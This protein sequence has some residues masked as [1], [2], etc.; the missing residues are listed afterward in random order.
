MKICH[1]SISF[2]CLLVFHLFI[3]L[4]LSRSPA[5]SVFPSKRKQSR[6]YLLSLNVCRMCMSISQRDLCRKKGRD[7]ISWMCSS[8]FRYVFCYRS[9]FLCRLWFSSSVSCCCVPNCVFFS[10]IATISVAAATVFPLFIYEAIVCLPVQLFLSAVCACVQYTHF[11]LLFILF[12]SFTTKHKLPNLFTT[13]KRTKKRQQFYSLLSFFFVC[14]CA[15]TYT[16]VVCVC[17]FPLCW[18]S[19]GFWTPILYI[20]VCVFCV[21]FST[22]S[23]N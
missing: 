23:R 10:S 1:L 3:I 9:R 8:F 6:N 11:I 20:S 2:N 12:S 15:H 17:G 5:R 19:L 22:P 13:S 4:S 16:V 7:K 21:C 14:L 18:L